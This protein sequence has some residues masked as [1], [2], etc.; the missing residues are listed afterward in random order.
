M[1]SVARLAVLRATVTLAPTATPALRHAFP[2]TE[3]GFHDGAEAS[4]DRDAPWRAASVRSARAAMPWDVTSCQGL[5]TPDV[6]GVGQRGREVE[7]SCANAS[8]ADRACHA[9]LLSG[10]ETLSEG[11]PAELRK[12][13][14]GT[15]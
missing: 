14:A 10:A 5:A 2:A 11:A 3:A 7:A 13:R 4:C 1:P 12:A 15:G 9:D 6:T 8:D